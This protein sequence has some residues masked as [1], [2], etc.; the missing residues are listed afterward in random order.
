MQNR[1]YCW[2]LGIYRLMS[3]QREFAA[4]LMPLSLV[5]NQ[6][7][8]F[9]HIFTPLTGAMAAILSALWENQG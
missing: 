7:Y 3:Q 1:S 9:G 8:T 6:F 2:L 4:G 5:V